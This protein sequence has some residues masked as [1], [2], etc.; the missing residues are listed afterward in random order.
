VGVRA[1][2]L[3][4][5]GVV[6]KEDRGE[7]QTLLRY[8]MATIKRTITSDEKM[9][10]RLRDNPHFAL[11]KLTAEKLGKMCDVTLYE[12]GS[13]ASYEHP[14]VL[15]YH[16]SLTNLYEIKMS[17]ADFRA[18][19][20]KPHRQSGP[21]PRFQYPHLGVYRYYVCPEGLIQPDE[22]PT[23]WGLYWVN[24]KRF[25]KKR[26]SATF[27]RCYRTELSLLTHAMR[28]YVNGGFNKELIIVKPYR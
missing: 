17:R 19:F 10:Q 3:R 4:V 1:Q 5:H 7:Y 9:D 22:L 14:D 2:A 8:I 18:D 28:T 11:C 12:Y 20:K 16:G 23:G 27:K 15:C 26:T 24:E 25:I 13:Y 21:T 6:R